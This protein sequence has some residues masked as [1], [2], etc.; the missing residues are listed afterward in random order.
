MGRKSNGREPYNVSI[1]KNLPTENRKILNSLD[2][3][4]RNLYATKEK[5]KAVTY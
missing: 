1:D 3:T 5:L 4:S 2:T